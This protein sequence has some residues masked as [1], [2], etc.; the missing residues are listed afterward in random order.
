[1]EDGVEYGGW[2]EE[3]VFCD[4]CGFGVRR[5]DDDD[6]VMVVEMACMGL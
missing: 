3:V 2:T 4:G 6:D 5:H 1:M